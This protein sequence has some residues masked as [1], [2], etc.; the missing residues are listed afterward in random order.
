MP[1]VCAVLVTYWPEPELFIKVIH[2]LEQQVNGIVIVDNSEKDQDR[3]F[4]QIKS[5]CRIHKIRCGMNKGVAAAQNIGIKWAKTNRFS[6]V[7]LMDQDSIPD[8][9][10]TDFL[11]N[12]M[13]ALEKT[14]ERV[15]ATGPKCFHRRYNGF[16]PFLIE[17]KYR[18]QRVRC[19]GEN[20]CFPVEYLIS[21]GSLIS[22]K[23]I[24]AVGGMDEGL[25][26]DFIDIEWGFRSQI[27]GYRSYAACQATLFHQLGSVAQ[28]RS[29]FKKRHIIQ[30]TPER[31]YYQFRNALL[32]FKKSHIPVSWIVYQVFRQ[33][34]PRFFIQ[35]LILSRR[36]ENLM[37]MVLGLFHGFC[38]ISGPF[39]PK[40]NQNQHE[41][42]S[43][44]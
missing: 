4:S 41:I 6:H 2:S 29:I 38:G 22:L 10:M 1:T 7:L 28:P 12:T 24:D 21:S 8:D 34:I 43:L 42:S 19:H 37:M 17:N 23:T 3:V 20:D 27:N 30:H 33:M 15:A 25:F 40:N 32:L 26:I 36:R 35:I 13:L 31:Y 39:E 11:M 44:K 18:I 9:G 14:G 5:R 16:E